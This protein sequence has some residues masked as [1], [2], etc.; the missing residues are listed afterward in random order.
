MHRI[1]DCDRG[2]ALGVE[3]DQVHLVHG[4][5]DVTHAEQ[6]EDVA[7]APGLRDHA[8][9][10]VDQHHREIGIGRAGRHVAGVLHVARRVGDDEPAPLGGE[11][12]IGDVDGDALLALRLQAVD[13]QREIEIAAGGAG[14]LALR[15]QRGELVVEQHLRIVEQT[16]DQ[17]ALAVIDA[18]AG[19]EAQRRPVAVTQPQRV[20]DASTGVSCIVHQK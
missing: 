3:S 17:R 18:A 14:D 12:P 15:R 20:E 10:G 1:F 19:D 6:A 2:E 4:Q 5:H 16:A 7:V 13:Q 8:L 11:E 9:A